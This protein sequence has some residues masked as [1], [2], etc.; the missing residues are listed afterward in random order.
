MFLNGFDD[1]LNFEPDALGFD[2]ELLHFALQQVLALACT[3]LGDRRNDGPYAGPHLEPAALNQVL[4][5]F[6]RGVGMNL[7]LGGE[8]SHRRKRLAGT[9][10]AADGGF[11]G[12]ENKL[13]KDGFTRPEREMEQCHMRIVTHVIVHVKRRCEPWWLGRFRTRFRFFGTSPSYAT[14]IVGLMFGLI[15][16]LR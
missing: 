6:V 8:E 11:L 1:I 15:H 4:D 9:Q 3:R 2:G 10:F 5:N 13:V 12:G 14:I 16:I 7:E